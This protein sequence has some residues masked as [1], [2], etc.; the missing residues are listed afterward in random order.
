MNI[1][2]VECISN[3]ILFEQ[4][5]ES[6]QPSFKVVTIAYTRFIGFILSIF[7]RENL[8]KITTNGCL[9]ITFALCL[10]AS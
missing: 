5:K 9:E 7:Q 4:N 10:L 1:S 2:I 3:D 6:I 8:D